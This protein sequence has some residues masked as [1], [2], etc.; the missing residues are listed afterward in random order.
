MDDLSFGEGGV[1]SSPL[2]MNIENHHEPPSELCSWRVMQG[3]RKG[4]LCGRTAKYKGEMVGE[5]IPGGVPTGWF[6]K[7]HINMLIKEKKMFHSSTTTESLKQDQQQQHDG[8]QFAKHQ[9]NIP[10][11]PNHGKKKRVTTLDE[12]SP[13]DTSIKS[14]QVTFGG[15]SINENPILGTD[16]EGDTIE[17]VKKP[18]RTTDNDEH[19]KPKVKMEMNSDDD[20]SEDSSSGGEEADSTSSSDGGEMEEPL[21]PTQSLLNQKRKRYKDIVT[22]LNAPAA[23][24][25]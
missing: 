23:W 3:K 11:Q 17:P 19:K 8:Y 5:L 2:L 9:K 13:K 7:R 12:D 15:M 16:E 21:D 10:Y 24:W 22:R 1:H 4:C 25:N 6:C 18:Q 20:S 14:G